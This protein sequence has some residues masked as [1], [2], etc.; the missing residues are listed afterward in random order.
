MTATLAFD[1]APGNDPVAAVNALR[2]TALVVT[3]IDAQHG[4]LVASVEAA[5]ADVLAAA[6]ALLGARPDVCGWATAEA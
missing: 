2:R 1:V 5:D 4:H 6:A 3:A